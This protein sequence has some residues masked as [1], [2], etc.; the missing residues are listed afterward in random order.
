MRWLSGFGRRIKAEQIVS[1]IQW[2]LCNSW[3]VCYAGDEVY[4][5]RDFDGVV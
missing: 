4:S 1:G 5:N 2:N 3:F